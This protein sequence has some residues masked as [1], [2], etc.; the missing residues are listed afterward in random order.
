VIFAANVHA[1]GGAG[2]GGSAA[3]VGSPLNAVRAAER[4]SGAGGSG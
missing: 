3:A 2:G 4:A 1:G